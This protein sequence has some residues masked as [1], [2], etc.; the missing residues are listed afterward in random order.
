MTPNICQGMELEKQYQL[1]DKRDDK[2][3]W[4]ARLR[5]NNCWMTQ[6]LDLDIN[7]THPLTSADSDIE[8]SWT[9]PAN[10][11]QNIIT[12]FPSHADRIL[13]YDPGEY[14]YT[15]PTQ[16]NSCGTSE[17][18]KLEG[19]P[20]WELVT[21]LSRSANEDERAH[22]LVGNYY[23]YE[24]ATA[25]YTFDT[26]NA[27]NSICPKGW[28][29]P[30][31]QASIAGTAIVKSYRNLLDNYGWVWNTGS[32]PD[33]ASNSLIGKIGDITYDIR[34]KPLYFVYSGAVTSNHLNGAGSY[35]SYRSSTAISVYW[36]YFIVLENS[37]NP[38]FD[39]ARFSGASVRCVA[40]S[41]STPNNNIEIMINPMISLD[42]ASEVVVEKSETNPSTAN[43]DVK[44]SSNQK[45]SVGISVSNPNLASTTSEVKIPSKSGLLNIAENGW[46]IK[47][48]NDTNYTALT[49]SLQTF[50]TASGAEIKIIPFIIGIST[51]PDIPNGEYST[52][53]TITATQN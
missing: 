9:P 8:N 41:E 3:Y 31:N 53:I 11:Q 46:G 13:S 27:P 10:T 12:N 7:T 25:G 18:S 40:R 1:V 2:T 50:Y 20:N 35:G 32:D 30:E 6:N 42:V 45:Y 51:A 22:Y 26:G 37:V 36:S 29:L 49:T 48:S 19:C 5:D 47:L 16:Q 4:I 23:S 21:G 33:K 43:L 17:I 34:L 15:T 39:N 38:S 28:K 44:V 52:D 24:I 14:I